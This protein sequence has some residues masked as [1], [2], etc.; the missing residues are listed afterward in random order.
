MRIKYARK[1]STL[2]MWLFYVQLL[3]GQNRYAFVRAVM[4]S[5]LRTVARKCSLGG[6][7]V[8]PGRLDIENLLKSPLIYSVSYFNL[9]ILVLFLEGKPT[10]ATPWRRDWI[11]LNCQL[12]TKLEMMHL[13]QAQ[14]WNCISAH[15]GC[16]IKKQ[17]GTN[18]ASKSQLNQATWTKTV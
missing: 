3:G 10:K 16:H 2:F 6:L 4:I 11:R 1:L 15:P 9:G 5:P 7:Y 18:D 17:N 8:C 13:L 12:V 14:V